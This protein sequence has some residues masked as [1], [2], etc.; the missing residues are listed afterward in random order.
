MELEEKII[1]NFIELLNDYLNHMKK[2]VININIPN[3]T[4]IV[5]IGINSII[6]IFKIV[7]NH[8]KNIDITKYYCQKAYYCY[9]EYIEQMNKTQSLHNLKLLDAITF[10]YKNVLNELYQSDTIPLQ[11]LSTPSSS[12]NYLDSS[13]GVKTLLP[14]SFFSQNKM[15]NIIYL[16]GQQESTNYKEKTNN[17]ENVLIEYSTI[18]SILKT[19]SLITQNLLFYF[20]E[21]E[22][23][24]IENL[25]NNSKIIDEIQYI[26]SIYLKKYLLL[27]HSKELG[28][29]IFNYIIKMRIQ[30][31]FDFNEYCDYLKNIYKILKNSTK[32][33][34]V[35]YI[36][37]KQI[38]LFYIEENKIQ[39]EKYKSEKKMNMIT[40]M[41]FL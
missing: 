36:N 23:E 7:L 15:T 33:Y 14:A 24:N 13:I 25:K 18:E 6:H 34:D 11:N 37:E 38:Q 41:M 22:F 19:I 35:L 8:T 5:C 20:I 10:I 29:H 30:Y 26:L 4:Y 17:N 39:I 9:L 1:H 31:K 12:S 2:T 3:Y 32:N 28:E 27:F 21:L 40:K 16:K